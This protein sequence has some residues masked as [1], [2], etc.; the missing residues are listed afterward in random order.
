WRRPTRGARAREAPS[1]TRSPPA[2]IPGPRSA[3]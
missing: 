3:T 1:P 2:T